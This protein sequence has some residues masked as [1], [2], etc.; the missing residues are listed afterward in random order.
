MDAIKQVDVVISAVAIPQHLDQFNII[1]AIKDIGI[2]N[3]KVIILFYIIFFNV[4]LL[5]YIAYRSN[6]LKFLDDYY[7]YFLFMYKNKKSV[8]YKFDILVTK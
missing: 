1:K 2:A 8:G 5:K 7:L 6:V 3:I 4:S